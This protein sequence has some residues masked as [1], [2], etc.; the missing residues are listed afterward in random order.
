MYYLA[1]NFS[2]REVSSVGSE[3]RLDRAGVAGS[4][5]VLPTKVQLNEFEKP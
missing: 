5:P 1:G 4:S 2:S 3:H